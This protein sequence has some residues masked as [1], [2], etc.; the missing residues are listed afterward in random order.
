MKTTRRRFL[1]AANC[2]AV[3]SI[4]ILNTLLNL[5]VA[6]SVAAASAPSAGEYRALVCVFQSGGNDSFNLLAPYSGESPT[7]AD[8]Y[9]E[10]AAARSDLA[11]PKSQLIEVSPLNTPGRTFGVHH[12]MPNLAALFEAGDAAFVANVGT[13]IEPVA[14]RAEVA[15]KLK[16]LP[17]GLYSHSDQIEQWQTSVPHSRSGVGWAGRMMDL[18]KDLNSNPIVSMNISADGSNVW[19]TGVTGAEYAISQGNAQEPNS[20]GAVALSGYQRGYDPNNAFTNAASTGTD[21]LLAVES[22]NLLEAAWQQ[23]RRDALAAYELYSAATAGDLPGNVAFPNTSLGRQLRQV[24][25]ALMGR[26][27]LGACRQTYFVNRGGWDHHSETVPLQEAMLP[28]VDG[29]LGAFWQQVAALGLQDQVLVFSAS[30][31]GRTLTSNGRGSDH[32]WGGNHFLIGGALRGRRIYGDYPGLALN[33]DSGAETN[34]LDTG[35]GRLIPTTSCDQFFAEMALWLGVPPADL[36][37]VL[38][39][40]GNFYAPSS[41]VAPLGFIL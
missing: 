21:G 24:A 11:L 7:A 1:G 8:A 39:N 22:A 33:P 36:P 3:S 5:R 32:A 30:D 13:L 27:A 12:G 19:Q 2:A 4:P 31:F 29:A 6:G 35:R 38:P 40:I 18:I 20:G 16:K 28:E 25:R 14:S 34:P 37:L 15:A 41:G 10:Y 23:K 9:T 17:L 26:S